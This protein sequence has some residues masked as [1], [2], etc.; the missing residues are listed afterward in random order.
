[1]TTKLKS[2]YRPDDM[3][4]TQDGLDMILAAENWFR[5]ILEKYPKHNPR[6]IAE[7][8]SD[9]FSIEASRKILRLRETG[10]LK[11]KQSPGDSAL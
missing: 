8:F 2:I 4:C 1:M 3:S 9:R 7:M 11:R 5:N 10:V 6:E